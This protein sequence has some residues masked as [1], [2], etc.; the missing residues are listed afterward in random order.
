MPEALHE[1][2]VRDWSA[3]ER[4]LFP[5][6]RLDHRGET[7][8]TSDDL[9]ARL[10]DGSAG[11]FD[12][13]VADHQSRGRGRRG[14]RWE[15]PP[16]RNLLFSL[17][18]ELVDDRSLWTRLPHLTGEIVGSAIESIL[19]PGGR[20]EAKWPNDLLV[21]GRKIA[22]ILVETVGTRRPHA[23]VGVGINVNVRTGEFPD[24][25]R[26][27]ATSLYELLGCESSRWFLLG[28]ILREFAASYPDK[29]TNFDRSLAWL[30]ERD[31]LRGRSLRLLS[32]NEE[33]GGVARGLGPGG[34]LL[35]ETGAGAIRPVLSAE[36]IWLCQGDGTESS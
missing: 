5:P 25:L 31:F 10:T 21:G 7:G 26:E 30:G 3:G 20:V 19:P 8:S 29:L 14:D 18:L 27:T 33:I 17:A 6:G 2:I 12:L 28:L 23:I 22:G 24:E 32:G 15:A 4:E 1:Q 11:H 34:E 16:G 36:R 35:V 13:V 9:A